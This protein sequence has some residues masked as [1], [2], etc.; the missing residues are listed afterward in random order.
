MR[1]ALISVVVVMFAALLSA[2]KPIV[3]SGTA[4]I[5]G[6]AVDSATRQPV[7][8]AIIR[9]TAPSLR[10]AREMP[11]DDAGRFTFAGLPAGRYTMTARKS[12]YL[13]M[14]YGSLRRRGVGS[15]ITVGDG[16]KKTDL[17]FALARGAVIT[18]T[19]TYPSGRPAAGIGVQAFERTQVAGRL[20]MAPGDSMVTDAQGGFRFADLAAGS[21]VVGTNNRAS[22]LGGNARV[23]SADDVA[24]AA[25]VARGSGAGDRPPPAGREMTIAQTFY[26][27]VTDV[28]T[29]APIDVET[30]AE[31]SGLNF[32]LQFV[33]VA[34]I[35]GTLLL[36]DGSAT[37][38]NISLAPVGAPGGIA[39]PQTVP[40]TT[41]TATPQGE[42]TL[43]AQAGRYTL[44][45]SL[46]RA[47][48]GGGRQTFW[49]RQ[50][51]AVDAGDI[52]GLVVRLQPGVLLSGR[53]V[54]EAGSKLDTTAVRVGVSIT[55]RDEAGSPGFGGTATSVGP[56]GEFRYQT[57]TPWTY[58]I[59]ANVSGSVAGPG[60]PPEWAIASVTMGGRDIFDRFVEIPP[61][62]S[63][64]DVVITMTNKPAS[65][66]GR[67]MDAAG[68]PAPELFVVLIPVDRA[69]WMERLSRSPRAL[70]PADDGTFRFEAVTPG[71]YYLAAATDFAPTDVA[72]AALLE[73]LL[74]GAV[75]VTVAAGQATVQDLRVGR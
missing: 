16:E 30:G 35:T 71:E 5:G 69:F 41:G 17:T 58:V 44:V 43:N 13:E 67:L 42:F 4:E 25:D 27:G 75:R 50:P 19:V 56:G 39:G 15:P 14:S 20:M 23:T 38:G 53:V 64:D 1:R 6:V 65:L 18:G 46:N 52:T 74:A 8:R 31:R 60:R 45:A 57:V 47:D 72:N 33:A 26:P 40:R 10:G 59:S 55:P 73:S 28:S 29:A 68:A 37:N 7:R 2:Q 51:L 34:R 22:M 61:G 48:G 24:W 21:Y 49:A 3:P 36:P 62:S 54:A 12:G 70:K 9:V 66:G 63:I 11:T 32:A